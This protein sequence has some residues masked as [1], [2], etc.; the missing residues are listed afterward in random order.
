MYQNGYEYIRLKRK[1]LVRQMQIN[2]SLKRQKR[3]GQRRNRYKG[4]K[5]QKKIEMYFKKIIN[6]KVSK[7]K[8]RKDQRVNQYT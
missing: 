2:K 5:R 1:N 8:K 4:S 6:T 3:K 7:D